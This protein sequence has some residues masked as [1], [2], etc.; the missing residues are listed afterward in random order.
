MG[1][2][3]I[4]MDNGNKLDEACFKCSFRE[5]CNCRCLKCVNLY[6]DKCL[7]RWSTFSLNTKDMLL[8]NSSRTLRLILRNVKHGKFNTTDYQCYKEDKIYINECQNYNKINFVDEIKYGKNF[9]SKK[10]KKRSYIIRKV[11]ML[12]SICLTK[13]AK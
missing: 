6:I 2:D 9:W 3:I 13:L 8:I 10:Y 4:N 7:I 5:E 1:K 12:I 11:S